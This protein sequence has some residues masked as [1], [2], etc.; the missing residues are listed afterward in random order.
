[1]AHP[2]LLIADIS[3]YGYQFAVSKIFVLSVLLVT[4][5]VALCRIKGEVADR[6]NKTINAKRNCG[7]ENIS[8]RSGGIS[9]G[10]QRGMVDDDDSNPTEEK[11]KQK[12]HKILV[13]HDDKLLFVK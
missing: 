4:D 8:K 5:N 12:A 1:M 9:L 7:E 10:L 13:F 3:V 2:L 11:C 6:C